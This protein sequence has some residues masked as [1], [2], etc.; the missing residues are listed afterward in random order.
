MPKRIERPF[1]ATISGIKVPVLNESLAAKA[2]GQ[3]VQTWPRMVA[4]GLAPKPFPLLGAKCWW[5]DELEAW[6]DAGCPKLR[7]RKAPS[8]RT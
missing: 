3:T 5:G 2:C 4:Q 7:R 8:T 1:M 6:R